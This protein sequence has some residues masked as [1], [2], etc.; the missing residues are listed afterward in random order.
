MANINKDFASEEMRN[1]LEETWD[2]INAEV[3]TLV[4]GMIAD[5]SNYNMGDRKKR[6]MLA[7]LP[8]EYEQALEVA[9]E[10]YFANFG[11]VTPVPVQAP[12]PVYAPAPT[13]SFAAACAANKPNKE[14]QR[15]VAPTE[16]QS[17]NAEVVFRRNYD[18]PEATRIEFSNGEFI[19]FPHLKPVEIYVLI[20]ELSK[21]RT[22]PFTFMREYR[23]FSQKKIGT[24]IDAIKLMLPELFTREQYYEAMNAMN[25]R[26]SGGRAIPGTL[27]L[28]NAQGKCIVTEQMSEN[29]KEAVV[30]HMTAFYRDNGFALP[31]E[32]YRRTLIGFAMHLM[33]KDYGAFLD[34]LR[35]ILED[36]GAKIIEAREL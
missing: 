26:V 36:S 19:L 5:I 34:E 17:S 31:E 23:R 10:Q 35:A 18:D 24:L 8:F 32:K 16:S 27:F 28:C 21:M 22:Q 20:E 30:A 29:V 4:D 1:F 14:L 6:L 2:K 11:K 25:H 15:V 33:L 9:K 7:K 13:Y 12:V 3:V